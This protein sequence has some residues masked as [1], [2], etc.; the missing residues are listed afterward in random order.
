MQTARRHDETTVLGMLRQLHEALRHSHATTPLAASLASSASEAALAATSAAS[1]PRGPLLGG[2][3]AGGGGVVA[4]EVSLLRTSASL[5]RLAA[6]HAAG[7]TRR[8]PTG[9]RHGVLPS[10]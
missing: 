9:G 1:L 3:M 8:R 6:G 7:L 2:A 5:P 10:P 4:D